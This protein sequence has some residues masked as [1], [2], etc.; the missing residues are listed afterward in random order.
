MEELDDRSSELHALRR[1]VAEL[2]Q[3]LDG[4]SLE[5][6]M[7]GLFDEFFEGIQLIDAEFRYVYVNET[8][9]EHAVAISHARWFSMSRRQRRNERKTS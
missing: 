9:A 3:Q 7:R 1:R 6:Y 2:E 8:A 4:S 5:A